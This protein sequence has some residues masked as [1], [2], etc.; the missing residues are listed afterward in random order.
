MPVTTPTRPHLASVIRR[1][2]SGIR[3]LTFAIRLFAFP[4]LH[5]KIR[6]PQC[7]ERFQ[8]PHQLAVPGGLV[9]PVPLECRAA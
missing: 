4:I 7:P 1:P 9:P 8:R 3:H 5:S 2:A 6:N